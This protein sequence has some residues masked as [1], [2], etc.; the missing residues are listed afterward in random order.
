MSI[1]KSKPVLG[2]NEDNV[3]NDRDIRMIRMN[4]DSHC[5]LKF[6]HSDHSETSILK[7]IDYLE[8]LFNEKPVR[9]IFPKT[10]R[11]KEIIKEISGSS[12][13]VAANYRNMKVHYYNLNYQYDEYIFLMTEDGLITY[14]NCAILLTKYQK[15]IKI[16][17]GTVEELI[18]KL[19]HLDPKMYIKIATNDFIEGETYY[20]NVNSIT[21]RVEYDHKRKSSKKCE[22]CGNLCIERERVETDRFYLVI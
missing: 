18:E 6:D 7:A 16:D 3:V 12:E 17:S 8:D 4:M 2:I 22:C 21:T 1:I 11:S 13:F 9:I 15:Q 20:N 19:K 5:V 14:Y 10:D